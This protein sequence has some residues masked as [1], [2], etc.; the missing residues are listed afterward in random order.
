[1]MPIPN[2][3]GEYILYTLGFLF[4]ILV[5]MVLVF[6]AKNCIGLKEYN[7]RHINYFVTLWVS[8]TYVVIN[9][10]DCT[11]MEFFNNFDGNN[12]I[13]IFWI[14]LILLSIL[15]INIFGIE[16][17]DMD[18]NY[19]DKIK[20]KLNETEKITD[21][22]TLNITQEN[23]V[24][25]KNKNKKEIINYDDIKLVRE[26]FSAAISEL[27]NDRKETLASTKD[28]GKDNE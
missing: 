24:S 1:M 13:F 3:F 7:Q 22:I 15:K 11:R 26:K 23:N 17:I 20:R 16:S 2:N 8:T 18:E 6:N 9:W 14:L 21:N 27:L 5:C 12:I 28:K 19:D 10:S 25:E 4:I